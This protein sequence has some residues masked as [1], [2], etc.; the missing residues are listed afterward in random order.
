[1]AFTTIDQVAADVL[2]RG[3][4]LGATRFDGWVGPAEHRDGDSEVFRLFTSPTFMEW[5]E[6]SDDDV[7]AQVSGNGMSEGRSAVW[8]RR[9]ARIKRCQ[10]GCAFWF[11]DAQEKTRDDPTARW[12]PP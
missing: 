12:P 9:E 1:M 7:L 4:G 5:L 10:S 2:S 6:I 3:D 11:A 8:V